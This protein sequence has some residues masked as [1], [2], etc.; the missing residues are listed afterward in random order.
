MEYKIYGEDGCV[1]GWLILPVLGMFATL[2]IAIWSIGTAAS[3]FGKILTFFSIPT[4]TEF[5]FAYF[6]TCLLVFGTG[7]T[8]VIGL[9]RIFT[10]SRKTKITTSMHY[11]IS[12]LMIISSVWLN[13]SM[14]T[15][16]G[17]GI[18][19]AH[20]YIVGM[21]GCLI[22]AAYFNLSKR[23]NRTFIK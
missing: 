10:Y 11:L 3:S 2:L 13:S 14:L 21:L 23:V 20:E 9:L 18:Y 16:F 6:I 19:G 8:A 7:I 15:A 1:S 12:F 4:F 17:K 22:W 5:A